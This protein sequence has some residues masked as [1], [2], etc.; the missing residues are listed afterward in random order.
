MGTSNVMG[1]RLSSA[2]FNKTRYSVLS[3]LFVNDDNSFYLREII[4]ELGL[5][6]GA[7]Q[8]ELAQLCEVGLVLRSRRGNQVFY[9]ANKESPIFPE[10][11]SLMVKTAGVSDTIKAALSPL[12]DNIKLAFIYGSFAEGKDNAT[13]D[14]DLLIV[15]SV[16]MRKLVSALQGAQRTLGREINPAVYG[17]DEFRRR[18]A[19]K[20]H[21]VSSV[22][23]AR[24]IYLVGDE[25]GLKGL[26]EKGLAQR[27]QHDP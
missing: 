21:F 19:E 24:K 2:L 17:I 27:A 14:I 15:G 5:G 11:K 3:L 1:S 13:S 8:R 20:H 16:T 12:E 9:Q 23:R 26:A 6:R 7:V 18:L 22:Y 25:R 4:A 10:L